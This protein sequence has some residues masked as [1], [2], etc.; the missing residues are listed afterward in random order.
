MQLQRGPEM[1][2]DIPGVWENPLLLGCGQVRG[3]WLR[4][5]QAPDVRGVGDGR[6]HG[7][8]LLS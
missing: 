4:T 2:L 7:G 6:G 3:D 8:G 5:A 1:L